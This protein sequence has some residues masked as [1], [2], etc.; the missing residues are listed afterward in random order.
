MNVWR[1]IG[2]L[3]AL[4]SFAAAV[5]AEA[6]QA[7]LS[8]GMEQVSAAGAGDT[9]V[10]V[11]VFYP[12]TST[13]HVQT[14]GPFQLDVAMAGDPV[15]RRLPLVV[16]SHG[17]GGS[18]F[19]SVNLA[20]ALAKAGFV[21]AAI[22]HPGDNYRDRRRSFA[23][24]NI[25]ARAQQVRAAIDLLID[26]W[27]HGAIV[28]PARIGMFGHSAGGATSLII[29]GGALDPG[30]LVRYCLG[31]PED[32][33]CRGARGTMPATNQ[34]PLGASQITAA[35]P[36]VKA[37]VLAAPALSHGFVPTGLARVRIPVQ[38]WVA[39]RD[40][41]VTDAGQVA[42]LLPA[43]PERHDVADAGHFSFLAPCPD[44]L[45]TA[46][47]QICTDQQ[48]FDRAAF[49]QEFTNAVIRFFRAHLRGKG[50]GVPVPT[51]NR[52]IASKPSIGEDRGR[53]RQAPD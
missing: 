37:L 18:A 4:A 7:S 44:G 27:R 36:R 19:D 21:V 10:P 49:Q 12:S 47:P 15:G 14:L 22:E 50:T 25:L 5:T 43:K 38:L 32:W 6:K 3:L 34:F 9:A 29:G 13:S 40:A 16:I 23:R 28:D 20:I 35:D 24:E 17:T 33:G 1:L 48:G 42:A 53:T 11:T 41:I 8:V 31:N 45:R 51:I 46:A 26:S 52:T 39:D 30:Q 2:G